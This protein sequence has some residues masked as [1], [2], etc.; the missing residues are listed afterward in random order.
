MKYNLD[1]FDIPRSEWERIAQ[2]WIFSERDRDIFICRYLD[3]TKFEDLAEQFDMSVR[4]V[5]KICY[6]TMEK[7]SKH[8]A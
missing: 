4:Q 1:D 2:E 8:L 5:K 3:G 7:I 6:K